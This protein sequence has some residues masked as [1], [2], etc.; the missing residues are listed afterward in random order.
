MARLKDKKDNLGYRGEGLKKKSDSLKKSQEEKVRWPK[1]KRKWPCQKLKGKHNFSILVE[2]RNL[3]T[4]TWE[5]WKCS[6]CGKRKY[7]SL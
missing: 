6:G 2:K 7:K 4:W 3:L 1:G 5:I